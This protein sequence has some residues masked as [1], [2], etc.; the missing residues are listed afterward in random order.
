[1]S[2]VNLIPADLRRG[3]GSGRTP[4]GAYLLLSGLAV[5]LIAVVTVV[6]MGNAV[7]DRKADLE[8]DKRET[9][10][11]TAVATALAPYE[12]VA[13][14][15]QTRVTAVAALIA[16]RFDWAR[17][18]EQLGMVV[19]EGVWLTSVGATARPD[20]SLEGAT[21]GTG[22]SIRSTQPTPAVELDGC[23]LDQ[24]R[25]A[26][27]VTRLELVQGVQRV[28]LTAS[29]KSD[30][31]GGSAAGGG[32]GSATGCGAKSEDIARFHIVVFLA[33]PGGDGAAPSAAGPATG[34]GAPAQ[35][36]AAPGAPATG[37]PAQGATAQPT[38][39]GSP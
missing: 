2:Q 11:A 14:A 29:E 5:A 28:T 24:A 23:A 10:L 37:A 12:S 22:G 17:V 4:I 6:L 32:D 9:E 21:S 1:M 36:A 35:P 13:S 15:S 26:G 34:S 31:P 7:D 20:V 27:L 39:G 18:F 25:V 38:A 30:A 33:P 16:G 19:P 3:S 8:K